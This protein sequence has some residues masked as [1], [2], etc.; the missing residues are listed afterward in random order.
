MGTSS[1]TNMRAQQHEHVVSPA[2]FVAPHLVPLWKCSISVH[3][4][5]SPNLNSVVCCM[6]RSW[7]SCAHL[8]ASC[9]ST[10]W[11]VGRGD[12]GHG[13]MYPCAAA[14]RLGWTNRAYRWFV[15]HVRS[16]PCSSVERVCTSV[17]P[18]G[19]IWLMP[20]TT[21]QG[22]VPPRVCAWCLPNLDCNKPLWQ[23]HWHE[24]SKNQMCTAWGC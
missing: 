5:E 11:S 6:M 23:R 24:L 20:R 13:M 21:R 18:C 15:H 8:I 7:H 16:L 22:L 12:E 19:P 1:T 14:S 9:S 3:C 10:A 2:S 17:R 4:S